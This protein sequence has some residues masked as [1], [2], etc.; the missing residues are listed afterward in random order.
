MPGVQF[1]HITGALDHDRVLE[2]AAG[3]SG[4]HVLSFCEDMA[5]AY[6]ACDLAVCRA[7]AS[8]MTELALVA[9]PSILV[10]YPYA[11]DDHQTENARVYED[12]G[13]AVLRQEAEL[14]AG[15]LVAELARILEDEP[16]RKDMSARA[17]AL[18]VRDAA[19]RI[20]DV[21]SADVLTG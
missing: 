7:G 20:C 12:A 1:L 17:E 5:S 6:A 14:D 16:I 21:I 15:T 9:M 11:A 18:A 10:P 4:Y 8:S 2:L 19:A 3:C 13:A